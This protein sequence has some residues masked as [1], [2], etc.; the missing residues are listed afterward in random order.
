MLRR[1]SC[2]TTFGLPSP[3]TKA[4]IMSRPQAPKMSQTTALSLICASSSS[5]STRFFSAVRAA[6]RPAR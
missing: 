6:T 4:A 1:A 3:A 2:A 5:F